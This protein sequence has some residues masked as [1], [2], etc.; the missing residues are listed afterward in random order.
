MTTELFGAL[1]I[2][3][4]IWIGSALVAVGLAGQPRAARVA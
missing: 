4:F 2:P 1:A 3:P